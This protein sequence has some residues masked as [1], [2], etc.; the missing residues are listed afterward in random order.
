ML[1]PNM[2]N[3]VSVVFRFSEVEEQPKKEEKPKKE[4]KVITDRWAHDLFDENDQ[5][6]KSHAELEERYGYDIRKDDMA[7][8][9]R[10][11]RLYG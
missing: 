8:R 2:K 3:G 5:A 1:L 7:P 4:N 9:A 10:R 11:K 6:P